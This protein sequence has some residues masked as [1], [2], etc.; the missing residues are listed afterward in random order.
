MSQKMSSGL[1]VAYCLNSCLTFVPKDKPLIDCSASGSPV[2]FNK[3][4]DFLSDLVI[5]VVIQTVESSKYYKHHRKSDNKIDVDQTGLGSWIH[6]AS[7]KFLVGPPSFPPVS[8]A[9]F[10]SQ[11]RKRQYNNHQEL[12]KCISRDFNWVLNV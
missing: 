10:P 7:Y 3:F 12:N 11:S 9:G 5:F 1:K 4:S 2:V 8:T 6:R